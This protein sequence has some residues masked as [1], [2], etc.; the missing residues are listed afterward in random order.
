MPKRS[1][2]LL[3]YRVAGDGTLELFL[4]HPGGPLWVK[5]DQHAWSV[6]KGEYDEGDEPSLAAEREFAE[7][8]GVPPPSGTRVDLGEIKQASGKLVRVWAIEVQ[9]FDVEQVV[10]NE[11]ELEWPPNSGRSQSFPEVDRAE[12]VSSAAARQKLV[13]GQIAFVD[14]LIEQLHDAGSERNATGSPASSQN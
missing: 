9:Q 11:F 7:E 2:G 12:W 4:V 14:R 3:P 10:S 1:A 13:K 8:L 5:K 6:A